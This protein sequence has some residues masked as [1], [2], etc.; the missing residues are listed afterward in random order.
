MKV[1]VGPAWIWIDSHDMMRME[2]GIARTGNTI[3][4]R[5][6]PSVNFET[7]LSID[8]EYC[9]H[10]KKKIPKELKLIFLAERLNPSS[11]SKTQIY[12]F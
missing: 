9:Y 4:H 6:S 12:E 2:W 11:N 3:F 10:C 8:S 1:F 7:E 5:H